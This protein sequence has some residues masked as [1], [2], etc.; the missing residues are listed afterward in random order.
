[1]VLEAYIEEN[2]KELS[3]DK[4]CDIELDVDDLVS[5]AAGERPAFVEVVSIYS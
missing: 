4:D 2:I 1:M 3:G 5:R